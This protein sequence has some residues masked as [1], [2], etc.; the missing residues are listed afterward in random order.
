MPMWPFS[1]GCRGDEGPAEDPGG[2]WEVDGSADWESGGYPL[3]RVPAAECAWQG[4]EGTQQVIEA[5]AACVTAR[6]L[7]SAAARFL[8]ARLP[9]F[10]SFPECKDNNGSSSTTTTTTTT[11]TDDSSSSSS[12]SS[13]CSSSGGSGGTSRARGVQDSAGAGV[14]AAGTDGLAAAALLSDLVW[15]YLELGA[16]GRVCVAALRRTA[17][18]MSR[19]GGG[20]GSGG[21]GRGRGK[22]KG[23]LSEGVGGSGSSIEEEERA[24]A[25]LEEGLRVEF[26]P[27]ECLCRLV[28]AGVES[29][30]TATTMAALATTATTATTTAS[31]PP[32]DKESSGGNTASRDAWGGRGGRL[33][34]KESSGAAA[35]M[36]GSAMDSA[37][38]P[39][40]VLVAYVELLRTLVARLETRDAGASGVGVAGE[41]PTR[42]TAKDW[43]GT[44]VRALNLETLFRGAVECS[45]ALPLLRK[46]VASKS[47][48]ARPKFTPQ[49]S[50]TMRSTPA[51]PEAAAPG[52]R[53]G[54]HGSGRGSEVVP[55]TAKRQKF[56]AAA[57]AAATKGPKDNTRWLGGHCVRRRDPGCRRRYSGGLRGVM[58][59]RDGEHED[60]EDEEEEAVFSDNLSRE[61]A[62]GSSESADESNGDSLS[63]TY[64]DQGTVEGAPKRAASTPRGKKR[65]AT[66][67]T[68]MMTPKMAAAGPWSETPASARRNVGASS[69]AAESSEINPW[70]SMPGLSLCQF[71]R[72]RLLL[73]VVLAARGGRGGGEP[74]RGEEGR[75]A[76]L[77]GPRFAEVLAQLAAGTGS[78]SALAID[79]VVESSASGGGSG[80]SG[81]RHPADEAVFLELSDQLESAEDGLLAGM[82]VEVLA[83]LSTGLPRAEATAALSWKGLGVVYPRGY[84]AG[85]SHLGGVLGGLRREGISLL[86]SPI[87]LR[88]FLN[89]RGGATSRLRGQLTFSPH[90]RNAAVLV[91]T[92]LPSLPFLQHALLTHWAL[93]GRVGRLWALAAAVADIEA[94]VLGTSGRLS[95]S[96]YDISS[97]KGESSSKRSDTRKTPSFSSSFPSTPPLCQDSFDTFVAAFVKL[98]PASL[99]LAAP[100]TP[101]TAATTATRGGRS[102]DSSSSPYEEAEC[103]GMVLE[104]LVEACTE[105]L[106]SG[107]WASSAG[108]EELTALRRLLRRLVF[109]VATCCTKALRALENQLGRSLAWRRSQPLAQK[110]DAMDYGAARLC[111]GL[112][113]QCDLCADAARALCTAVRAATFSE[114]KDVAADGKTS[115]TSKPHRAALDRVVKV[116][117]GMVLQSD[118][119]SSTVDNARG[120]LQLPRK[121]SGDRGGDKDEAFADRQRRRPPPKTLTRASERLL[122]RFVAGGGG[123]RACAGRV[124]ET[125]RG[126]APSR[127]KGEKRLLSLGAQ[128]TTSWT[129]VG[130][131]KNGFRDSTARTPAAAPAFTV[132]ALA[133]LATPRYVARGDV[134]PIERPSRD[135]SSTTARGAAAQD[136]IEDDGR[137]ASNSNNTAASSVQGET[138]E[139]DTRGGVVGSGNAAAA[140]PASGGNVALARGGTTHS[141]E[142]VEGGTTSDYREADGYEGFADEEEEEEEEE[143]DQFRAVGGWGTYF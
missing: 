64:D 27:L 99:S 67:M 51:R 141:A 52:R 116:L 6:S 138:V 28:T 59:G 30:V 53:G 49:K 26:I 107:A 56:S 127:K 132:Q 54:I 118:R 98:L 7:I 108:T 37:S 82:I 8:L 47:T 126:V 10:G 85:Y 17:R 78:S 11:T 25:R 135:S 113:E 89:R 46:A 55:G 40:V 123:Q 97:S 137:A 21:R 42:G 133:G 29:R 61:S 45:K 75:A 68:P 110:G 122:S 77:S 95:P 22:K 15:R 103:L 86:S 125:S 35:T 129:R 66:A 71:W 139:G 50:G 60:E 101:A 117:P 31:L 84:G 93:A 1:D 128:L 63:D 142:G 72:Y 131:F 3:W 105:S 79:G 16:R 20:G 119:L 2:Y 19:S 41:E 44:G 104:C 13:S 57:A 81:S 96:V 48:R 32:I 43:T 100:S 80:G 136:V 14:A 90:L 94:F 36:G 106:D 23:D 69:L 9:A 76:G 70:E 83:A 134:R 114:Q 18:D 34:A 102:R 39:S 111:G 109:P 130:S 92:G 12:S 91:R 140:S 115:S 143:V 38:T 88:F 58:E 120:V 124:V 5:G 24:A 65:A 87:S 62:W 33:H 74:D 121:P 112:L 73:E 4:R